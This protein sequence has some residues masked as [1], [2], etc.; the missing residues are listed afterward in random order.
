[1]INKLPLISDLKI[2]SGDRVLVRIDCNVPLDSSGN[3]EDD[4]RLTSVFDTLNYIKDAGGVA[5]IA[6]AIGRPKGVF[7]P[8]LTTQP[9]AKYFAEHIYS[10]CEYIMTVPTADD[11]FLS[12]EACKPGEAVV[13][14]NLRFFPEE[15]KNDEDFAKVLS[16][17]ADFYVN[18]AFGQ[19]HRKQ[20]SICAITNY[21]PSYAGFCLSRE[22]AALENVLENGR[23]PVVAIIGGAKV[24]DK[25]KVIEKLLERCSYILIGGAMAFTFMKSSGQEIGKSLYEEEFVQLAGEWLSSGKIVIPSDFVLANSIDSQETVISSSIENDQA[26]FDIGPETISNFKNILSNANT[27]LWNG[28]MGVFEKEQFANGTNE[29]GTMV[30]NS[31]AY[32]VVGGGDSVAAIR[33]LKIEN[34]IDHVSTGGGATLEYIEQG[35]LVGIEALK[36]STN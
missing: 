36:N 6:G 14:E 24:S 9:I 3:I 1:M 33:K 4:F 21:L 18:D 15:E 34:K 22:V 23:D 27:V 20:A 8:S 2:A 30:A 10:K 32:C 17:L 31:N 12:I 16:T 26:G 13:L 25:M 28:P 35:T 19:S 29:I 7:D 11:T 5:I